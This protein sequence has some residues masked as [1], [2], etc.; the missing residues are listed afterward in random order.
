MSD[1]RKMSKLITSEIH[2]HL[3]LPIYTPIDKCERK[4][5]NLKEYMDRCKNH[6]YHLFITGVLA[7]CLTNK[8][9]NYKYCLPTESN[10]YFVN[11]AHIGYYTYDEWFVV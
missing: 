4:L 11:N 6:L 10:D 5:I 9:M 8:M 7:G 3:N 2:A 1:K